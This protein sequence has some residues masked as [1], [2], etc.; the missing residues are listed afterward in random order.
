[1]ITT[2]EPLFKIEIGEESLLI[3]TIT[4]EVISRNYATDQGVITSRPDYAADSNSYGK[5]H[6]ARPPGAII[7]PEKL[8]KLRAD[9]INDL[10]SAGFRTD[11]PISSIT[12][13][14]RTLGESLVKNLK[15]S[16]TQ[17]NNPGVWAYLTL[18][19]FWE[20]P[21]WRYPG[22]RQSSTTFGVLGNEDEFQRNFQRSAGGARNVLRKCW[23]RTTAL[24][25]DLGTD[26]LS[27]TVEVLNEDELVN[28]FE[29]TTLA[30]SRELLRAIVETIYIKRPTSQDR[31][32]AVRRFA[33]A[34]LHRTPTIHFGIL[35]E[36]LLPTLS[37]IFDEVNPNS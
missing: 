1:M 36:K 24:G 5:G 4:K 11:T 25:P 2:I 27:A 6:I 13:W 14:D 31:M 35:G 28:V 12:N 19:V 8:M 20:F 26:G 23:I 15:M 16:L 22:R 29:R 32:F 3:P 33:S 34:V 10:E 17:A 9:V 30:N 18:Y 37:D 21:T 7:S